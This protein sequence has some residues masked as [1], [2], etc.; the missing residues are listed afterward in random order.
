M[1]FVH[2]GQEV[3]LFLAQTP[4]HRRCGK[5]AH[6]ATEQLKNVSPRLAARGGGDLATKT[7]EDGREAPLAVVYQA[8]VPLD[9]PSGELIFGGTGRAKIHAGWQ[10]LG[11]RLWRGLCQTFRF[12]M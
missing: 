6:I 9:D 7:T 12:S 11:Q 8:S 10:S 2:A 5:I 1:D 3:E 4:G